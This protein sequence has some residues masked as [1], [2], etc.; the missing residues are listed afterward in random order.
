MLRNVIARYVA[1]S[2]IKKESLH[3]LHK[4]TPMD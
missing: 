2:T 4:N 1:D 3:K